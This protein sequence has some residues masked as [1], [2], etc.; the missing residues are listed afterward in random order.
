MN[1]AVAALAVVAVLVL[2]AFVVMRS[3]KRRP[4]EW[5]AAPAT[6]GMEPVGELDP[7]LTAAIIAL[8]RPPCPGPCA[9]ADVVAD[10]HLPI[11]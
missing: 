8:H 7:A 5:D 3:R 1:G 10:P 9:Q 2:I 6:L 4:G 11:S